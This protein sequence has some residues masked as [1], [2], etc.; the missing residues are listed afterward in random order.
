MAQSITKYSEIQNDELEALR[1]IY[2]EDFS[3]EGVKTG[4][5]NVRSDNFPSDDISCVEIRSILIPND[6]ML[7]L[8]SLRCFFSYSFTREARSAL[9]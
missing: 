1:S 8:F 3:E 2:M 5:W 9:R 6:C 4:A 7:E